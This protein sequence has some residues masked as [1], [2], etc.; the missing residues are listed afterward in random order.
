MG[1]AAELDVLSKDARSRALAYWNYGIIA[2]RL[3]IVT[4][5]KDI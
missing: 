2:R 1:E 4:T 5:I 3:L